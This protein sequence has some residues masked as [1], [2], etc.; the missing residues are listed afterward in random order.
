[1][2]AW[3]TYPIEIGNKNV[4]CQGVPRL[5]LIFLSDISLVL[6]GQKQVFEILQGQVT[7]CA[8]ALKPRRETGL[9]IVMLGGPKARQSKVQDGKYW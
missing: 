8:D 2:E 4:Q 6:L 5:V 3:R 9:D 7:K 1:M